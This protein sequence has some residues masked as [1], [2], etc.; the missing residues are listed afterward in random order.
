[1]KKLLNKILAYVMLICVMCSVSLQTSAQTIDAITTSPDNSATYYTG[2][3]TDAT[4]GY[5]TDETGGSFE[6]STVF[7]LHT[8]AFEEDNV[9]GSSTDKGTTENT[10]DFTWPLGGLGAQTLTITAAYGDFN[11]ETI[12]MNSAGASVAGGTYNGSTQFDMNGTGLR[13]ITFPAVNT[14]TS[15]DVVMNLAFNDANVVAGRP[16]VVQFSTDGVT[17]TDMTDTNSDNEW[18]GNGS[19]NLQFELTSGQKANSVRFRILQENSNS[20]TAG[21]ESWTFDADDFTLE[22]GGIVVEANAVVDNYNIEIPSTSITQ[23]RDF[24]DNPVGTYY[25]GQS[26]RIIGGFTGASGQ[27]NDWNYVALFIDPSNEFNNFTL[28]SPTEANDGVNEI[29]VTGTIPADVDYN[30]NWDVELRA[31]TTGTPIF[32]VEF[33]TNFSDGNSDGLIYIGGEDVGNHAEFTEDNDRSLTTPSVNVGT[34]TNSY[35]SFD[36]A[37]TSAGLSPSGT[38]I[39]VSYSTN[40]GSSYT[41]LEEISLNA[42]LSETIMVDSWPAGTVSTTTMFRIS[43]KSN[44]GEGLSTWSVDNLRVSIGG[45][46]IT[47]DEVISY[48]SSSIDVNEPTIVLDPVEVP[49]ALIYPG[50]Q[51]DL[52]YNITN[53]GYP[54]GTTLSAIFEPGSDNPYIIGSS[55]LITPG[56]S[57]DHTIEITVPAFVGG[58]YSVHLIP[59]IDSDANSNAVSLP[60]YNTTINITEVNSN[61]GVTD[62]GTEIIYPGDIITVQY[63]T[64]GNIGAGAELM[65]EVYDYDD[66]VDDYVLLNSTTTINGSITGTLPTGINYDG[67]GNPTVR[68]RIGNGVL[69]ESG[70]TFA[71]DGE[72][73]DANGVDPFEENFFPP[74]QLIGTKTS[75][76]GDGEYDNFISSGERSVAT[77]AFD[78]T[79]GGTAYVSF[80]EVSYSGTSQSVYLQASTD[81]GATWTTI[82]EETYEGNDF[83][84]FAVVPSNLWSSATSFRVIYNEAGESA[85][86]DNELDFG[87]ATFQVNQTST[88]NS[89][90]YDIS[91]QFRKPSVRLESLDSYSFLAGESLDIEYTTEGTFPAN[92]QFA[93]VL[94]GPDNLETVVGQST[95]QGLA[96]V[97][98]TIP[99]FVFED[100]PDDTDE[101]Y[102]EL[103]VVAFDATSSA[104]YVPDETITL[105]DDDFFVVIEGTDEEDG[106]YTFDNAGDRSL[107]TLDFDLSSA[108]AVQLNFTISALGIDVNDNTLTIPVLQAS[109]D[110][111]TTFNNIAA[112]DDGVLGDGFLFNNTAYS[113]ELDAGLLTAA[114]RFRW[115]Q[116]LNLGQNTDQ[117]TISGISLTLVTGNEI[118][119]YY[120]TQNSEVGATLN[121]P[122][123]D[124]YSWEQAN[125][126][127]DPVF[128]GETF[129]Y[130][131]IQLFETSDDFPTGTQFDF[132]LYDN[133][134]REFIMDP[135]TDR[136]FIIATTN[137]V[138]TGLTATIPFYVEEGSYEVRLIASV[139]GFNDGSY[140]YH[141]DGNGESTTIVG[142]IDVF[143]RA[144]KTTL[145][146]DANATIYAGSDLTFS[147]DLENDDLNGIVTTDLFANLIVEYDGKDWLLAAP[148][149]IADITVALP[150]FV[151]GNNLEFR[152][153]LSEDA[154]LGTIGE[155][156]EDNPLMTLEDGTVG[157]GRGPANFLNPG[158]YADLSNVGTDNEQ[159]DSEVISFE[160]ISGRRM[161]TT[162]DFLVGELDEATVLSFDLSFDQLPENLTA[163]QFLVFEFSVDGGTTYT[164]LMSFPESDAEETLNDDQF[165][166]EVTDAMK[167][168]DIRFRWRQEEN[169]GSISLNDVGFNFGEVLPF[170]Y[171]PELVDISR[172]ALLINSVS[173]ESICRNDQ[174]TI[175]YEIRGRFGA[176]NIV[177]VEW[178]KSNGD[179]GDVPGSNTLLVEGTGSIDISLPNVLDQDDN[180]TNFKFRLLADDDTNDDYNFNVNGPI[181]EQNVEIVAPIDIDT[182]FS[183][184]SQ[185]LCDLE[186]IEV[187]ID[188]QNHFSYELINL[189]DDSSLGTLTHDPDNGISSIDIGMLVDPI[190][191][192][193]IITSNNS[194]GTATCNT[195]R[196]TYTDELVVLPNYRLQRDR[197]YGSNFAFSSGET[198]D[199]CEGDDKVTLRAGRINSN[200]TNV[201]TTSNIEWFV[202]DETTVPPTDFSTPVATGATL[203]EFFT[204]GNY[205]GRITDGSCT[206]TTDFITINISSTPDRP[207]I[208]VVSGNLLDCADALEVVLEAPAGFTNYLWSNGETTR[209]ITVDDPGSYTVSVSN[210]S[211]DL[212]CGSS[213]SVAVVVEAV[214]APE[215]EVLTNSSYD[216]D[217]IINTGTALTSCE[218]RVIYFFEDGGYGNDG[219]VNIYQDGTLYASTNNNNFTITE[220]GTYRAEWQNDEISMTCLRSSGD[221][222]VTI[223]DTVDT[224]PV[225]TSTGTL[226]FCEGEGTVTLTA[227]ANFA[228]YVWYRNG[229]IANSSNDGFGATNNTWTVSEGGIYSVAVGNSSSCISSV[230]NIIEITERSLPTIP[231][232]FFQS[233]S[234]CGEGGV[235]VTISN[236]SNDSQFT[237]QLVNRAT[238]QPT[239]QPVEGAEDDEIVL[240]TDPITEATQLYIEVSY[241]D[242]SSC[243]NSDETDYIT[244]QPD[245]VVLEL[246]GTT[247]EAIVT[248]WSSGYEISWYRN[249]VLLVNRMGDD[250]ISVSDNA[251]YSVMVEFENGCTVTS[252]SID[253]SNEPAEEEEE[254]ES[255]VVSSIAFPNPAQQTMN[256]EISGSDFGVYE[257][258]IMTMTGQ[259]M[260][261]EVVTK[262][263]EDFA[264]P[265]PLTQLDRGLY[266]L[267][268]SNRNEFKNIRI[269][270]Q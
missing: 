212:G 113:A 196:S 253:L 57:E 215:F 233:S 130:D 185:K 247:L 159:F 101:L 197:N 37:K 134:P 156:L 13:R 34:V 153:E 182:E 45:N 209:T 52:V 4:V 106:T 63:S 181:S 21:A 100:N 145:V 246:T 44:N 143:L 16:I 108:D 40:G 161:I 139:T 20:L 50:D 135:S 23:F 25:A 248:E 128:N 87:S 77:I 97:S 251:T 240:T 178:I 56:D 166:F 123:L 204:S 173:S 222:T 11:A 62:G 73:N 54:A 201:S 86:F 172:Q 121:H 68:L 254:T 162:R 218:S 19:L 158:E 1:M 75:D 72:G 14:N 61:S 231:G 221:F 152:V 266:N 41:V 119:T 157:E 12:E 174:L 241:R 10:I 8:G 177:S 120:T 95:T 265:I 55:T 234:S 18:F 49:S 260:I 232:S 90:E 96:S 27:V 206:Y 259:V 28:E 92:T 117:W 207:E 31:Y 29:T 32:G 192:G 51:L 171:I 200:T 70:L 43:Q 2:D 189:A 243:T 110:G 194:D 190:D 118:T 60:I 227:P 191:I 107:Q 98:V 84:L 83:D 33:F 64:D 71:E 132:I 219:L 89:D 258:S 168:A 129:T 17:Y 46:V 154:P 48:V 205:F 7:Y 35:L 146:A 148:Q 140:F 208:T 213:S 230:S 58:T 144:L 76:S 88:A 22:I 53:G 202:T 163:S 175:N 170:D 133:G 36:L 167:A 150:P 195:L 239:G 131:W 268:V 65:L 249:D 237:Y 225:L 74:A 78:Y 155:T 149:D 6:S 203:D 116:P 250:W 15:E 67:G 80:S 105:D 147:L 256:V 226:S 263:V 94:G 176:E 220:S 38:E 235:N 109:T 151:S 91:G 85:E 136:P 5:T 81:N 115:Y 26:V 180:N 138:G 30:D 188:I 66:D 79:F 160:A 217:N 69:A 127:S 236:A 184:S 93:I 214:D 270:K 122:D 125:A 104:T 262:D 3:D 223:F 199:V 164:E 257:I 114:T 124:D 261:F 198:E 24:D 126:D 59:S 47:N 245:N 224:T 99:N 252:N 193:L 210:V 267:R 244:V 216:Q 103:K 187:S 137:A 183:L 82:D 179:D 169:K 141:G 269:L 42:D 165:L 186:S 142:S 39:E 242:G 112:E 229:S 255:G 264:V 102:D 211:F 238:G 111:G 9:L 228:T